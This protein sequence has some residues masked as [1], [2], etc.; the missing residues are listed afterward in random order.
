[1]KLS[2]S[3]MAVVAAASEDA[4]EMGSGMQWPNE[5]TDLDSMLN[6]YAVEH[7]FAGRVAGTTLYVTSSDRKDGVSTEVQPGQTKK[8]WLVT[9]HEQM[10]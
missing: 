1:M 10:L 8:L 9:C 4:D 7:K 6:V 5:P 2:P 3:P